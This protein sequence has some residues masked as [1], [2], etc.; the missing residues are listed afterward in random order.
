MI[1]R[2]PDL[3][4]IS[5]IGHS[6]GGLIARYAV[7]KLY[8]QDCTNQSCQRNGNVEKLEKSVTEVN[9]SEQNSNGKIGRLEPVNFISVA[10]PHLG[11]RGHRQVIKTS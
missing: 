5:F 1:Q 4:K 11:S 9:L 7:A 8:T 2:H 3:H 6:L 10:T